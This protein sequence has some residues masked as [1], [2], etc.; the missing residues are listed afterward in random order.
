MNGLC[1]YAATSTPEVVALRHSFK[2]ISI[3]TPF[4]QKDARFL[5]DA[6]VSLSRTSLELDGRFKKMG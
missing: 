3:I 6:Y 5:L 4:V 2:A 1:T